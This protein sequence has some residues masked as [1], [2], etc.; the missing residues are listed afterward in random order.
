[1]ELEFHQK[2]FGYFEGYFFKE[3]KLMELE[4]HL[5]L[6]FPKLEYQKSDRFLYISEIVVYSYIFP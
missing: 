3:L 4:Y 2:N 6:N 5:E 1:M